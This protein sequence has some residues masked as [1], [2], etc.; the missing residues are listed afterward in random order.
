MIKAHLLER[1]NVSN[2]MSEDCTK[3][4]AEML[5]YSLRRKYPDVTLDFV[6][7]ELDLVSMPSI[8]AVFRS[9]NMLTPKGDSSG[10]VRA[11]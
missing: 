3:A 7:N 4:L 9:V 11:V 5:F 1:T 8:M 6:E 2:S 10:E